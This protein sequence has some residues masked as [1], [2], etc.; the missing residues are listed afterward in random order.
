M[1]SITYLTEYLRLHS[2]KITLENHTHF[3]LEFGDLTDL[4]SKLPSALLN[5]TFYTYTI[6]YFADTFSDLQRFQEE[7]ASIYDNTIDYDKGT[8]RI[9]IEKAK[10]ISLFNNNL[11]NTFIYSTVANFVKHFFIRRNM[12]LLDPNYITNIFILENIQN[13]TFKNKYLSISNLNDLP[14]KIQDNLKQI[15]LDLFESIRNN[16]DTKEI[17]QFYHIP[18][19]WDF[20]Y[21][22]DF[23]YQCKIKCLETFFNLISNKEK[24]AGKKYLIKGHHNLEFT[25]NYDQ[26][27]INTKSFV[28][29]I[30][31]TLDKER[32]YDKLLIVRNV[33]TTYLNNYSTISQL[34]QQI[35][36][37][38]ATSQHHFELYIQNE[39][40]IFIEQKN[41]VLNETLAVAKNVS[42]LT[43]EITNNFKNLLITLF[44]GIIVSVIPFVIENNSEKLLLNILAATY[45]IYLIVNYYISYKINVQLSNFL[46][47]FKTYTIYISS[48][49]LNGL[50]YA[51]LKEKFILNEEQNFRNGLGVYR[52]L[53]ILLAIVCLV[54]IVVTNLT[55]ITEYW[56]ILKR[57]IVLNN[58]I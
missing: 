10:V 35:D 34:N 14:T 12:V 5:S 41:Q 50:D 33:L 43:V 20:Q 13:K 58:N 7:I 21:S 18:H 39:M 22:E 2:N 26:V 25:I 6:N 1:T 3:I 42:Q 47:N 38:Y 45:L 17:T 52:G 36:E 44:A 30:N 4:Y 29:L 37:V 46:D 23:L 15:D 54:F 53:I 27:E 51:T 28:E 19:F 16:Y 11:Q 56:L 24:V 48:Q 55:T 32:H 40:K 57:W 9:T 49:S 31:F 8:I